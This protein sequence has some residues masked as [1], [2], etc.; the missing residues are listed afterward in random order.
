[1]NLQQGRRE[2]HG[3]GAITLCPLS[4]LYLLW[5]SHLQGAGRASPP[6]SQPAD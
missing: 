1:M 3:W 2:E 4:D 6:P 5:V